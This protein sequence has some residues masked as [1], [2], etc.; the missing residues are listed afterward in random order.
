MHPRWGVSGSG[1]YGDH[2]PS[3]SYQQR[4]A[5]ECLGDPNHAPA[6]ARLRPIHTGPLSPTPIYET[7]S[8][9]KSEKTAAFSGTDI[10][11]DVAFAPPLLEKKKK[12]Q[13]Q[14][15]WHTK[16]NY[17]YCSTHHIIFILFIIVLNSGVQY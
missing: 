9:I 7:H 5:A 8:P 3:P 1:C 14:T 15:P 16:I 6:H 12:E 13:H 17:I 4:S 10:G 11:V 2:L